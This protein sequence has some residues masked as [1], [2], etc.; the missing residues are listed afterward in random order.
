MKTALRVAFLLLLLS[1][2]AAADINWSR[3]IPGLGP[4]TTE[5]PVGG[6]SINLEDGLPD[7]KPAKPASP[8][9]GGDGFA[10]EDALAPACETNMME[11]L[12][13][14]VSNQE[15]ILN[16]ICK[17]GKFSDDEDEDTHSET[18]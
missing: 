5:R 1:G 9:A 7:L 12:N 13:K 3:L 17:S 16:A 11:K 14:V 6:K 4:K 18:R 15:M 8:A 2:I 10:L